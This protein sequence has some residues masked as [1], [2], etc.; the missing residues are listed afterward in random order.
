VR[1]LY[2][3]ASTEGCAGGPGGPGVFLAG[4]VIQPADIAAVPGLVAFADPAYQASRQLKLVGSS[5]ATLGR[6][7]DLP[8]P[9]PTRNFADGPESNTAWTLQ[10]LAVMLLIALGGFTRA[11]P[12]AVG[13]LRGRVAA[14]L[15]ALLPAPSKLGSANGRGNGRLGKVNGRLAR[16][17]GGGGRMNRRPATANLEGWQEPEPTAGDAE[18]HESLT[19]ERT[20]S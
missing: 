1:K 20:R 7:L 6:R 16:A 17:N 4:G 2:R 14:A 5:F 12:L 3:L 11:A 18:Q 9:S 13:R 8:S 19:P 10:L 15:T